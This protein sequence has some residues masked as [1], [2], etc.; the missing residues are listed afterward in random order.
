[1]K[2][3]VKIK[4]EIIDTTTPIHHIEC[5]YENEFGE[6]YCE[7]IS[8]DRYYLGQIIAQGDTKEELEENEIMRHH[9]RIAIDFDGVIIT[10]KEY[11]PNMYKPGGIPTQLRDDAK[12][13]ITKLYKDGYELYIWTARDE[14][15]YKDMMKDLKR[16]GLLRFFSTPHYTGFSG[17]IGADYYIDDKSVS[18][19]RT[20]KEI[21]KYIRGEE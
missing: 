11:D 3:Y 12:K 20:W 9:E 16:F 10:T 6:L 19:I 17:K 4:N 18:N 14:Q 1:M 7:S 21:Y 5:Y 8:G 15:G 2:K 13:Y